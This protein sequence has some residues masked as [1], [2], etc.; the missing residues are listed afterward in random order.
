MRSLPEHITVSDSMTRRI[1]LLLEYDGTHF[2]GWQAQANGRTVQVVIESAIREVFHEA[3][4][5]V[6]AGR[7]DTGVHAY[8]QVAHFD[9]N[10]S[11]AHLQRRPHPYHP[12]WLGQSCHR[13]GCTDSTPGPVP[14]SRPSL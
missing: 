10:G 9:L 11:S 3:I 2:V 1:A 6:G 12:F 5:I 7:T 13:V 4:R 8:G 14:I